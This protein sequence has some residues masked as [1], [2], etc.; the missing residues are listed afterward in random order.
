LYFWVKN[1]G[2]KNMRKN[3][4][5]WKSKIKEFEKLDITKVAFCKQENINLSTFK[6][7]CYRLYPKS[8]NNSSFV[9]I[10]PI[11]SSVTKLIFEYPNGIKI[12]VPEG[13]NSATLRILLNAI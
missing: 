5:Y 1:I 7:W 8:N 9:S 12:H 3:R 13:I 6:N 10:T 4:E 11:E 2:I